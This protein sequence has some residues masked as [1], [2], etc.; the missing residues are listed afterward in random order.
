DEF[1]E[2]VQNTFAGRSNEAEVVGKLGNE[3]TDWQNEIFRTTINTEHNLS[4]YGSVKDVMPYR[5]SFGYTNLNGILKTSSMDRYTG[6]FALSPTLLNNDLKANLNGKFMYVKNRFAN[7][8]AI[9]AAVAFDPTQPVY[10]ENSLFGGFWS[11]L[12]ADGSL[13]TVAGK[14]PMSLL[15]M[16]SDKS[17]AFN[18][19]GNAQIDYRLPFLPELHFNLNLGMD[20]SHSSGSRYVSEWAPAEWVNGGFDGKWDQDRRNSLLDFYAQY[21]KDLDFLNSNLD[22]MAGYSWQHYWVKGSNQDYRIAKFDPFGN[23]EEISVNSYENEHYILSFFGRLNYT[24]NNKYLFTFTLRNDGS[25][26]FHP[27]RRWGLF[28]SA[29]VAWKI[30]D[31]DFMSPITPVM[32]NLKLRLGWGI[33]GQQDINQ[34][35]YP[36]MGQ[37]QYSVGQ[38]A[39]YIRGYDAYG[40]PIWSDLIRPLSYN[41]YLTWES[42]TTYNVGIDYAFLKTRIYG[43]IDFYYRETKDLINAETKVAAGTNF[44]EYV[45]AN[46]GSLKNT[47]IEFSIQ[48]VAVED[49]DWRWEIGANFA[50]NNN[51]ITSLS[52][53]D[54]KSAIRRYGHTGGDGGFQLM[55]HSV[56]NSAGMYYV[57]QQIYDANG[58][59]IEGFYKDRNNDGQIN[60]QD[61]YI[62]HK[63]TPDWTLGFNT[64]LMWKDWDLSIVGHGSIGNYNFN[65]V[66]ANN[67]ELAPARVYANEFLGNRVRSAFEPGFLFKQVLSDYYIQNASFFRIDNI[68][69]GWSFK[70]LWN[71][72]LSGRIY[73]SVQNPFIF[74]PYKGMDPEVNGGV[75][76][77]FYP[78]PLT[79]MLGVNIN[80]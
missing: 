67:A 72:P 50:Y 19:I 39:C 62:F 14:N 69:L 60:E 11:W 8:G 43:A 59:P 10:D 28:P 74:T 2:F 20:Y 41:E 65:A 38:Q 27:D 64:K 56:G 46:I 37:Y 1:R 57:Y 78:R 34:G 66:A 32:N 70:K 25:S 18:F 22:I 33:T 16:H 54:N 44:S 31:E 52:Y 76:N 21:K 30:S 53:G 49:K 42:T 63:P 13:N 29:A 55:V 12:G 47:G 73:G 3:N 15:E 77:N 6:S 51:E 26:R 71:L 4:V 9:G 79:C 45:P 36:Y 48:G 61:L 80:F 24:I 40:N 75:D 17:T 35:D 58:K 23:P 68:T 7:Q 5:V